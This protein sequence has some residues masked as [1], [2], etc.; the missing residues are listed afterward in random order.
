MRTR[1]V[2]VVPQRLR[3]RLADEGDRRK[4]DDQVHLGGGAPEHSLHLVLAPQVRLH[5]PQPVGCPRHAGTHGVHG[6][7]VAARQVVL[8]V[9]V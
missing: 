5:K 9:Y 2:V 7:Q 3:H 8:G 6:A 1:D 4:V